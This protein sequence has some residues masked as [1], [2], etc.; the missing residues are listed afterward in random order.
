MQWDLTGSSLGDSPKE[1]GSSLG[2]RREI[3]GK[4]I[5]G[6][7]AR[8]LEVARV[9]GNLA[10]LLPTPSTSLRRGGNTWRDRSLGSSHKKLNAM[11]MSPG[12]HGAAWEKSH[13]KQFEVIQHTQE[14]SREG[15]DHG[16]YNKE[17]LGALLR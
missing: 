1:S 9:C 17:L 5:R 7:A 16:R 2:T 6:L 4:K 14:K 12:G 8:L 3:A 10:M 15:H 13:V 11:E